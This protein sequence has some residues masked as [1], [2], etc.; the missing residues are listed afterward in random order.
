MFHVKIRNHFQIDKG[1]ILLLRKSF[2]ET[3]QMKELLS[4]MKLMQGRHI[5]VSEISAYFAEQGI[6]VGT[7]TIY[8]NLERMIAQGV[9]T[10][11]VMDGNTSACFEYIGDQECSHKP[12]CYHCKCEKC[13]KL[14]HL[15][16][17]EITA[18]EQHM[19]KHHDL[20]LNALRTV[21]YGIC[22]DCRESNSLQLK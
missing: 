17:N 6:A 12:S 18:L 3:K 4:Y 21:F 13:G 9:V 7:T 5:T 19:L 22:K 20:E 16:C 14:I 11:Y 1:E 8:R 10:K 2:Y 15:Q